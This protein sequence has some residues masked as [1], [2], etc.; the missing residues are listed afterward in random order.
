MNIDDENIK[1]LAEKWA[2]KPK[3]L[4]VDDEQNILN[5]LNRLFFDENYDV[6]LANSPKEAMEILGLLEAS[7]IVSDQRMPQCTGVEFLVD[8]RKIQP[9]AVRIL[10]TGYADVEAASRAV[11]ESEIYR[12]ISKPW[13]DLELKAVIKQAVDLYNLRRSNKELFELNIRQNEELKFLNESLNQKVKERTKV[14]LQKNQE[15][16]ELNNRLFESFTKIVRLVVDLI[17]TKSIELSSHC[18]RIAAASRFIASEMEIPDEAIETIEIAAML[19]DIGKISLSDQS[20]N[21]RENMMSAEELQQWQRHPLQGERILAHIDNLVEV[22]RIIR[23]HHEN[24]NGTGFPD[25]LR[26]DEIPLGSRIIAVADSFDNLVNK[27]YLNVDNTRTRAIKA[28]RL[29]MGME[30]D[31]N[32]VSKMITFLQ[33]HKPKAEARRELEIKPFELKENMILSR[34]LFTTRGVLVFS[35]DKRLDAASI[36]SILDSERLEKLLTSV[37][38]Y[39]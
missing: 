31:P 20:I 19:H 26:A 35:K 13:N 11:N 1:A 34:D 23:H 6:L 29:K 37:Y 12:Y 38:I 7:V 9:D 21:K 36:K 32:I 27:T 8:A 17:E 30:L 33:T 15:L 5:S 16:S 4:F 10:L 22:R 28:L 2:N 18:K 3:I 24:F 25:R 39:D 14:I